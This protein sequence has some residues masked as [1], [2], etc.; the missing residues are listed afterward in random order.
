MIK[1]SKEQQKMYDDAFKDKEITTLEARVK[2][3]EKA[4]RLTI[5]DLLMPHP[6]EKDIDHAK[7]MLL[8]ALKKEDEPA[9]PEREKRLEEALREY[10]KHKAAC[11]FL[12]TDDGSGRL[13]KML[14]KGF[15]CSCGL[16]DALKEADDADE[17]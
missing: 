6:T 10:G 7:G 3:L 14:G 13:T 2:E 17:Q 11:A 4:A 5:V 12:L 8:D 16:A 15:A 1:D 9:K